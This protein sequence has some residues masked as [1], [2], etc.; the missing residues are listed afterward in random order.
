LPTHG[1]N[2]STDNGNDNE[3]NN[4]TFSHEMIRQYST[5]HHYIGDDRAIEVQLHVQLTF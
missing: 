1:K 5:P 4:G 3:N 2:R